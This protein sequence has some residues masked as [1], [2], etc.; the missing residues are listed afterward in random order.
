MDPWSHNWIRKH[1]RL[2]HISVDRG[3]A[4]V[5]VSVELVV[6]GAMQV[7]R[8]QGKP[9]RKTAQSSKEKRM[10]L[11]NAAFRTRDIGA[12]SSSTSSSFSMASASLVTSLAASLSSRATSVY[13]PILAQDVSSVCPESESIKLPPEKADRSWSNLPCCGRLLHWTHWTGKI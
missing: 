9:H 6:G 2:N 13:S 4:E 12:S 10:E 3:R 11:M 1:Q 7:A 5:N 8:S